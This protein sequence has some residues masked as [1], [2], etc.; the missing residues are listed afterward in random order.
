M[1]KNGFESDEEEQWYMEQ[2]REQENRKFAE[3]HHQLL[4]AQLDSLAQEIG[5][6][7]SISFLEDLKLQEK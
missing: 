2:T 3:D 6:D 1:N 4:L 5:I 7:Y